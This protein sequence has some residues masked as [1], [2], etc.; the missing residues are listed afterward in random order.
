MINVKDQLKIGSIINF[1][2]AGAHILKFA[3]MS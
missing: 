2:V 3:N 1:I